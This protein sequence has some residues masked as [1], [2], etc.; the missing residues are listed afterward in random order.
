MRFL[1]IDECKE[2]KDNCDRVST[3][4]RNSPGGFACYCKPG[5][6]RKDASSCE[7]M[8]KLDRSYVCNDNN[9]NNNN[10]DSEDNINNNYSRDNNNNNDSNVNKQKYFISSQAEF[11]KITTPCRDNFCFCV[12]GVTCPSFSVDR[13]SHG[14]LKPARCFQ[15]GQNKYQDR[16]TL[17][18]DHGYVPYT[19]SAVNATCGLYKYWIPYPTTCTGN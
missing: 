8:L 1:D 17:V 6:D 10:N 19:P 9:N 12:A 14:T 18:C 4:C 2:G 13:D 5:Y 15:Q 3:I 7:R 11:M 16:C